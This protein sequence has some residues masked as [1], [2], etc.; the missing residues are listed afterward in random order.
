MFLS[1][2]KKSVVL[3]AI[4]LTVILLLSLTQIAQ[5]S[6]AMQAGPSDE[7][8]GQFSS[9][10]RSEFE[11]LAPQ[12]HNFE[13][14]NDPDWSGYWCY[15]DD[16]GSYNISSSCNDQTSSVYLNSGY[17]VR[18]YR[19]QNQGGP[20]ICFNHSDE[21]LNNNTYEDGS[22][23]DNTISSFTL[24]NQAWCGTTPTPAYPLEVYND[25]NYAGHWCYSAVAETGNIATACN[26]AV[27]SILLRPGWSVR[28]YRDQNQGGSSYCLNSSNADLSNNTFGSGEAMNNA[29]S[30]LTLYVEPNCDGG[31]PAIPVEPELPPTTTCPVPFYYN[32]DPRWANNKFGTCSCTIG[33]CG[34]AVSSLA[35]TFK[36]YGANHNPGSL[37][38]CLGE[39]ACP[40][41][42][43]Q[44]CSGG[45]VKFEGYTSFDWNRLEQEIAKGQLVIL[46]LAPMHFVVVVSGSGNSAQNYW[47]NDPGISGGT[48]IRL[49]AVLARGYTL[50][51]GVT[52]MRIWSGT[53]DC[54]TASAN[55]PLP[56][57][58][59][60]LSLSAPQSITGTITLY[61]NTETTM[62]LQLAAESLNG[63]VTEMLI[64]TDT[65]DN[66]IWQ[67][68]TEYVALPLLSLIH[69]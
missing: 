12:N 34:C 3:S 39:S 20:S 59:P 40:L 11:I 37:A 41:V 64:W 67:P 7:H 32:A 38:T 4:L 10:K 14:Y 27:S 43:S 65:T 31:S 42:W 15:S 48:R 61:R 17:S 35:M 28:V 66:T 52:A 23:M 26:D 29:I 55:H 5:P 24:Y 33:K 2:L 13:V 45:K 16:T 1:T 54:S 44:A 36:Y 53:P 49:S 9:V 69:I 8:E 60:T 51:S 21:N 6:A 50:G 62:T 46:R 22:A 25:A 68:F 47:V 18:L 56:L 30:S 63:D 57:T 58:I 19:D